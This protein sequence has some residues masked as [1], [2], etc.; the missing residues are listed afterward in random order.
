MDVGKVNGRWL[1]TGHRLHYG[2]RLLALT[3]VLRAVLALAELLV[4]F[5]SKL[6]NYYDFTK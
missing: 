2:L 6:Y 1:Y 4:Y 3:S 5:E